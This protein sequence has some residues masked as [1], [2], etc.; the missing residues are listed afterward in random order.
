MARPV[1]MSALGI[2]GSLAGSLGLSGG[3]LALSLDFGTRLTTVQIFSW[4]FIAGFFGVF[5][6]TAFFRSLVLPDELTWPFSRANAAFIAAFYKGV[7]E[8]GAD[9]T[10]DTLRVFGLFC[11]VVFVWFAV[12][13][14]LAPPLLTDE[15]LAALATADYAK[16][17]D[18]YVKEASA[19][20]YIGA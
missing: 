19:A 17:T 8:D 7:H 4:A 6:G 14:Y 1:G 20:E 5:F 15:K 13:N 2:A 10:A 16:Y 18:E 9:G 11:G 3:M 12:P